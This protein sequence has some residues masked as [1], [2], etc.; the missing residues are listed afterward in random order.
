MLFAQDY[1]T[2]FFLNDSYSFEAKIH[3]GYYNVFPR[4]KMM[5]DGSLHTRAEQHITNVF[6]VINVPE[7]RDDGI[8]FWDLSRNVSEVINPSS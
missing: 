6:C 8:C 5:K 1:D 4:M 3:H 2:S 7:V